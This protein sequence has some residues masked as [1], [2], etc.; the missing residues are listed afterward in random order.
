[1]SVR[2]INVDIALQPKQ[3]ELW[4]LVDDSPKTKIGYGGSRGAGKSG[5]ARRILILRRLKYAGT[6]GLIL[7]RT[8]GELFKNHLEPL[9][10]EFP[11][12]Q[13]WWIEKHK[14]L[15]FPND[16]KLFFGYAEYEK[17]VKD[18][19]GSEFGD[20]CPEE[21]ALFSE[22]ELEMLSGSC[23]WTGV[24]GFVPK[25]IFPFMPGGLGHHYLKRIFYDRDFQGTER[26][27]DFAFI[28]AYGW[29]NVEW[30]REAL[31]ADGLSARDYY[32]WSD[33][34]RREYFITR[35]N[36]GRELA[37]IGDAQLRAAWL[38]GSMEITEGSVF[39][40]LRDS[41]HNLDN[42]VSD[43][44][45]DEWAKWLK[46]IGCIDH[47]SSG[48]TAYVQ[49]G[50][51]SDDNQFGCEE[52]YERN[53]T[54][55]QHAIAIKSM[56]QRYGPQEY[57]LIDPSTEAKT[58]QGRNPVTNRDELWS[59]QDEYRRHGV[60]ALSGFR[61]AV[62]VGLDLLKTKLLIDPNRVHPF[63]QK[64]GSPALFISKKRCPNLWREMQQ[65]QRVFTAEGKWQFVGSDHALDCLR[66]IAMSRPQAPEKPAID[67]S[68]MDQM[69]LKAARSLSRFDATFGKDPNSN[70]WFPQR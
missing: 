12:M 47:A 61:T 8:Y 56:K 53:K 41:V 30:A 14:V 19:V 43:K 1:M 22:R 10:R 24:S 17:D 69:T 58:L 29:D 64:K 31:Q 66:Y 48:V 38:D 51:D 49:T 18:F 13:E 5:G 60:E 68:Q 3:E 62:S 2:E 34:E 27:D 65:L 32:A 50:L 45:W 44:M 36:Y 35:T 11:F 39:P 54:V 55:A 37:G 59:V 15:V 52:Y 28:Q 20:I 26:A 6:N 23:R 63:T 7:R 46:K 70:E 67:T 57:T 33:L 4:R 21:A 25:M 16:S 9:F 42:F 40:E